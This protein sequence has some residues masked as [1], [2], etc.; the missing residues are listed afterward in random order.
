MSAR[1]RLT[2]LVSGAS[3]VVGSALLRELHEVDVIGLVHSGRLGPG[4]GDAQAV[5]ADVSAPRMGLDEHTWRE[6]AARTDVIIHSAGLTDFSAPERRHQA[7][8]VAGTERML[9]LASAAEA[10]VHHISTSWVQAMEPDATLPLERG[11]AIHAY[12]SSKV[13]AERLV[14]E[15]GVSH[16]F[17][18]PS[19]LIGDSRTGRVG[20]RQFIPQLTL[21]TLRGRLPLL[22]ARPGARL[23]MVPDD[24]CARAIGACALAGDVGST[25]WLTYGAASPTIPELVEIC[26][27]YARE[28]GRS[29]TPPAVVDP[30]R[31]DEV[32]AQLAR[33]PVQQ[34]GL[35]PWLVQLSAGIT[36]GGVF[37]SSLAQLGERYDLPVPDLRD[38]LRRGL[39]FLVGDQGALAPA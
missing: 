8:N 20:A 36:A 23:D 30:D 10:P 29:F 18:R 28:T 15:S 13:T 38:A 4:A 24:V 22:P 3:G 31:P 6:L 39:E 27:Q 17:Y 34:R 25:Y 11:N 2:V 37:P 1:S 16:S 5:R 9:E 7:I 14:R 32:E 19:N 33:L 26:A 35:F 21:E 12:V